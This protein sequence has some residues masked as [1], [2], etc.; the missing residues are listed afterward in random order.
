MAITTR[1]GKGSE[2]T[3]NDLDTNFTDLRDGVNPLVTGASGTGIKVDSLGTPSFGWHDLTGELSRASA[4]SPP[5]C[6]ELRSGGKVRV[7]FYS[8]GDDSDCVFHMPHDYVPGTDLYLH[9]H[10]THNGTNISGNFVLNVFTTYAKGHQQANFSA[11]ISP[12]ITV[13]GLNNTNCP[14]YHHR[15]DEIQLTSSTPGANQLNTNLIEVDGL[16]M[17]HFEVATIPT[18]TGGTINEPAILTIDL[19]YQSS[20]LATKNKSPAFYAA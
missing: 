13:A 7:W 15:V 5:T 4:A 12:T 20:N 1:A 8:V 3:H 18:I 9:A 10:W 19:H 2:L 14:Q 17:F 11:E 6:S 16:F